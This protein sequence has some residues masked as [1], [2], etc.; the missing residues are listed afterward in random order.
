MHTE[1]RGGNS[2]DVIVVHVNV[3]RRCHNE[4]K[5]SPHRPNGRGHAHH[6]TR[7]AEMTK[8]TDVERFRA[9]V[10]VSGGGCWE[11]IGEIR[12]D[13]YGIFWLG[14]RK[15]RAHRWSYENHRGPIPPQLELDHLCR[16]PRC[17][18]ADHLE[19]VTHAEN[20]RRG[21]AKGAS[22]WIAATHCSKGHPYTDENSRFVHRRTGYTQRYCA[23][24][25]KEYDH[26][27]YASRRSRG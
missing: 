14:G 8:P 11:W 16:N 2:I 22:L 20:I 4:Q 10:V 21:A 26:V 24:C 13:G 25:K 7:G 1:P 6:L 3:A 5:V 19:P 23:A 12:R 17:V 18:N 15:V 27:R 9:R